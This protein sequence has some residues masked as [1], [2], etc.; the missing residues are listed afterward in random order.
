MMGVTGNKTARI[1]NMS[2]TRTSR[3]DHSFRD[4]EAGA[5]T[6]DESQGERLVLSLRPAPVAISRMLGESIKV[7]ADDSAN[8][9]SG[10]CQGDDN[11][12]EGHTCLLEWV[13]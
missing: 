1:A 8:R 9:Y 7:S 12:N 11:L 4:C 5:G 3:N 10:D 6:Y 2:P 13:L